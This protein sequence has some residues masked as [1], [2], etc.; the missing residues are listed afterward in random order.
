MCCGSFFVDAMNSGGH[1]KDALG[2]FD[3]LAG[4]LVDDLIEQLQH[5]VVREAGF[6][7]LQLTHIQVAPGGVRL[8]V[9]PLDD[10]RV[11][12]SSCRLSGAIFK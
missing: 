3:P 2:Q 1:V 12:A 4:A 9:Q 7:Y 8:L 5:K 10:G 6:Q 11:R